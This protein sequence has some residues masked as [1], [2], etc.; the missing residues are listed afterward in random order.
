MLYS[1]RVHDHIP[2][3]YYNGGLACVA[4]PHFPGS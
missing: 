3:A 4:S 1:P 2:E